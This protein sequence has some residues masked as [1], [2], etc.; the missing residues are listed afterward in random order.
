MQLLVNS[1]IHENPN[2]EAILA[3][4]P[5]YVRTKRNDG[6]VLLKYEQ[7]RSDFSIPVV[8]E[9]RGVILDETDGYKPVCV[10]F[11]KFG[12]FGEN[13]V[14]DIDWL[15]ARVQEKIDGSLIKLWHDKGE[16]HISSNGEIDARN[17]HIDSGL[18]DRQGTNLFDLFQIAW[19]KTGVDMDGL[20]RDFIYMFELT[21]PQNRVVIRYADTTI[22]HIGTRDMRTLKECGMNI[23]IAQPKTYP[24]STLDE[25]LDVAKALG[26]DA[27]GFVVV[28]KD[29]NRVKIKSPQYVRLSHFAAGAATHADI[30]RILQRSEQAEFLSYFP[31]YGAIFQEIASRMEAFIKRQEQLAQEVRAQKYT[32]RKEM[33][34]VVLRT[35]CPGCLFAL[36]DGKSSSA[37]DWLMEC[38]ADKVLRWIYSEGLQTSS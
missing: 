37:H 6:Y 38:P 5:Y 2:W 22:T 7:T 26:G 23:G 11:F 29:Y 25:C 36:M 30:V 33:A 32:S 3:Q 8:R 28:D 34:A 19:R 24:L 13:Y 1:F 4:K 15:S 31:E 14:P 35:E 18:S 21:S 27:E 12:N 20:D 17:A 10:P 16:W 9:C